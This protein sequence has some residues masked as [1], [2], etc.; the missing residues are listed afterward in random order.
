MSSDPLFGP[1]LTSGGM[2]VAVSGAA[3]L[4]ALLRFEGELAL[5][6][7]GL[8]LIPEEAALAISAACSPEAFDLETLGREAV[9]A[10]GPVVPLVAALR[11]ACGP[12][13]PHVHHG[14]TSQDAMDTAMMLVARDAIDVLRRDLGE[15]ASECASLARRHRDDPMAGRTLL[16]QA[17]P[18]TFGLKA[19]TWL[20]G[21]LEAGRG[22]E[23]CRGRLAL[24]LGGPVGTLEGFGD[25]G[26]ALVVD[27]AGRL[28]LAAPAAAWHSN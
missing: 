16:Q 19:A 27:L 6:E 28:G 21:V 1:A 9:L 18:I 25:R 4:R 7:G 12:A 24:Q 5:A 23:A 17:L 11:R 20:E 22:L 8:G 13:A 15:L 10:A 14:A 3:W 26:A 2:A